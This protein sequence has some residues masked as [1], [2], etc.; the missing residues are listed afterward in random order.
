MGILSER[1]LTG[2]EPIA[3]RA[4]DTGGGV[5]AGGSQRRHA[6]RSSLAANFL[7]VPGCQSKRTAAQDQVI[8]IRDLV[9]RLAA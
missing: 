4:I 6:K 5:S 2:Q 9:Y 3:Q 7:L 1:G 8:A